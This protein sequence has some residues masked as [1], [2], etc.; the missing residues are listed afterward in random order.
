[1]AA[2]HESTNEDEWEKIYGELC[3]LSE[4][5]SEKTHPHGVN[6][7]TAYGDGSAPLFVIKDESGNVIEAAY[8]YDMEYEEE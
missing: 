6:A 3:D 8:S 5:D 7:S 2:K 4:H 1:M